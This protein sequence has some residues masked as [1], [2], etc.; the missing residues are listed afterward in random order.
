MPGYDASHF[1]PLQA[2]WNGAC[3]NHQKGSAYFCGRQSGNCCGD[4]L[5][6]FFLMR[7][8]YAY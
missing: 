5:H 1:E 7:S 3:Y 6:V 2:L 8:L 4:R